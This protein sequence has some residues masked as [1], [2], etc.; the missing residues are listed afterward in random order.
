MAISAPTVFEVRTAGSDTQCGGGFDPA[1]GGTDYSQQNAAQATGTA[2]SAGTTLTATTGI[3]TSQMVGNLVT[4]GTTWK[5]IT[6]FTSSTVVTI[7]S[8]PSWTTQTIYVGGALA[9]PRK[10]G[11]IGVAQNGYWFKSGTYSDGTSPVFV[12]GTTSTPSFLRGY[13][14]TRG[15]RGAKPIFRCSAGVAALTFNTSGGSDRFY[16]VDNIDLDGNDVASSTGTA[17][18]GSLQADVRMTDCVVRRAA[19]DGISGD[20]A[21]YGFRTYVHSNGGDGIEAG[22]IIL[23]NCV[24]RGNTADGIH[25]SGTVDI[26]L[27]GCLVYSNTGSGVEGRMLRTARDTIIYGNG[28]DGWTITDADVRTM[29][30]DFHNLIIYGNGGYGINVGSTVWAVLEKMLAPYYI[31]AGSN[32][33][34]NYN[35]FGNPPG[36]ISLTANPF[37]DAANGNFALNSTAGGGAACRAAGFPGVFPGGLTTGYLDVGAV[38]HQDIVYSP[39]T[40][41]LG[42]S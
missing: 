4:N 13:E 35:G 41:R 1:F 10:A 39:V 38:Q 2:T 6:A 18:T 8:D 25:T 29:G 5:Q 24:I 34:G 3:F 21:L 12:G 16:C 42:P 37:V 33:S 40:W 20:I 28:S 14:T 17:R 15:D 36:H 27:F 11:S 23:H 26:Q 22:G 30:Y 7:D 19:G 32:T 9:T 31:A